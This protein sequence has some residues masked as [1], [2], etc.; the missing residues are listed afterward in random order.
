MW[1]VREATPSQRGHRK[2]HTERLRWDSNQGPS[3]CTVRLKEQPIQI[4]T[5]NIQ[6]EIKECNAHFL[7]TGAVSHFSL[8]QEN[9]PY[10]HWSTVH[11]ESHIYIVSMLTVM[12]RSLKVCV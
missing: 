3:F 10:N 4:M 1:I 2:L 5:N 7:I 9:S 6:K 8:A 11:N 12:I